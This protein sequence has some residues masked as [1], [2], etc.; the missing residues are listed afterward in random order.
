MEAD[1]TSLNEAEGVTVNVT[2]NT[3]SGKSKQKLVPIITKRAD[4]VGFALPADKSKQSGVTKAPISAATILSNAS[5]TDPKTKQAHLAPTGKRS[6]ASGVCPWCRKTPFHLRFQC[7]LVIQRGPALMKRLDEL[8]RG[9]ASGRE[10]GGPQMAKELEDWLETEERRDRL[11]AA[12]SKSGAP[13]RGKKKADTPE[14]DEDEDSKSEIIDIDATEDEDEDEDDRADSVP[15]SLERPA[16]SANSL[17]AVQKPGEGSEST[18]TS[19]EG[20]QDISLVLDDEDA[21]MHD[22]SRESTPQADGVRRTNGK[23]TSKTSSSSSSSESSSPVRRSGTIQA[24]QTRV[25]N[26]PLTIRSPQSFRLING[27]PSDIPDDM[28]H[29]QMVHATANIIVPDSEDSENED[30]ADVDG[31]LPSHVTMDEDVRD[32]LFLQ[33]G[34]PVAKGR[35]LGTPSRI[36]VM[37]DR[38]GHTAPVSRTYGD[39]EDEDEGSLSPKAPPFP[40][41]KL[42][43]C[44]SL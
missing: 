6:Q 4:T 35:A 21:D 29:N 26:A 25:N 36:Q 7:P 32:A 11:R 2:V 1:A 3:N 13:T 34:S 30:M 28:V 22:A 10:T 43:V 18:S 39:N 31:P 37:K 24:S 20:E 40:D 15:L 41:H 8:K 44:A 16:R 14:T 19:E 9:G 5:T 17:V 12:N 33:R 27:E 23:A 42:K 38:H